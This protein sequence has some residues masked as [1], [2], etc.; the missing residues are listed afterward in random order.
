EAMACG[1]TVVASR[2]GGLATT[3]QHGVTGVLV[4]P[5]DEVALAS[6][7]ASLLADTPRRRILGAQAARWAQSFSWP[8]VARALIDLYEELVPDLRQPA[9]PPVSERPPADPPRSQTVVA[10][11][12]RHVGAPY[13]WGGS[14]PSGFD[15]S[16]LVRYVYAQ[17]GV[18]LPHNAAQQYRLGTPVTRD[19]LEPGDLVF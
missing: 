5:R 15:C 7:I 14:S 12:K 13:R 3:I 1:A 4:P 10:L 11:A 17:V 19:G 9:P 2:V 16:G 8:S 6:A 18:E